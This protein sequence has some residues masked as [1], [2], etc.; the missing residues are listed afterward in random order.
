MGEIYIICLILENFKLENKGI[1]IKYDKV[2]NYISIY[3]ININ[4]L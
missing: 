2:F 4:I 3:K 1:C